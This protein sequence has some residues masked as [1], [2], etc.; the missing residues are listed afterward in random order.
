MAALVGALKELCD[1][2]FALWMYVDEYPSGVDA[3]D[4]P[5]RGYID[6]DTIDRLVANALFLSD[7][8]EDLNIAIYENLQTRLEYLISGIV[9]YLKKVL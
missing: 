8:F 4:P 2:H 7:T 1:Q 9:H 6:F 3:T 5:L